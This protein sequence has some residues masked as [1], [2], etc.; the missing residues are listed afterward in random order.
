MWV[1]DLGSL[2]PDGLWGCTRTGRAHPFL[3]RSPN[4]G[5]AFLP[6]AK[7]SI[8]RVQRKMRSPKSRD[9]DNHSHWIQPLARMKSGMFSGFLLE[10]HELEIF[11]CVQ[12][13]ANSKRGAE[14]PGFVGDEGEKKQS[15]P[16]R[17]W[18]YVLVL[19]YPQQQ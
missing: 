17:F 13:N 11:I 15:D 10:E 2:G 18:P 19:D 8:S 1:R 5:G 4:S 9:C 6:L 12:Y 14:T 16:K 3:P 7:L